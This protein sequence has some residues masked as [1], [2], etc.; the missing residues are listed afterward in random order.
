MATTKETANSLRLIELK[1][2]N[3]KR[4]QA[5]DIQF[6]NGVTIISGR[7]AQGKTSII[8]AIEGAIRG[9]RYRGDSFL[10]RGAG[11]GDVYVDLGRLRVYVELSEDGAER[12]RVTGSDGTPMKSPQAVLDRLYDEFTF[13][14]LAFTRMDPAKQRE[15]LIDL[16][17]L[18]DMLAE[19]EAERD[20]AAG[21]RKSHGDMLE[22][23]DRRLKALPAPKAGLPRE[24]VSVDD[25]TAQ[26]T[27][28]QTTASENAKVRAGLTT[29][30]GELAR[31]RQT[32]QD[33]VASLASYEER[34][35]AM[36]KAIEAERSAIKAR[37]ADLE[38]ERQRLAHLVDPSMDEIRSQLAE[39]VDTNKQVHAAH[40]WFS[41]DG[42]IGEAK[43]RYETA[44][45]DVKALDDRKKQCLAE[46][47][48]PVA[49]LGF[50]AESGVTY[51]GLPFS[52]ASSAEQLRV[53]AKV[54][55][56]RHPELR[57][58]HV[59]DGSLLDAQ[60][61]KILAECA[62]DEDY[63]VIVERVADEK[64]GGEVYIEDGMVAS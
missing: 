34:V 17:G 21:Q 12:L 30:E 61:M 35:A 28:M 60:S 13:D 52:S 42:Q 45:E 53:S 24:P 18:R 43:K 5:V 39:I 51:N 58:M 7:N 47:K 36:R 2:R 57:L 19:I 46:A 3:V 40:E 29:R 20:R 31:M 38:V 6:S 44:C 8:K 63:Q 50:D 16:L 26:L 54:G 56:S 64:R 1:A 32:L 11:S 59:E 48:W 33:H 55:M 9:K 22:Y 27:E 14:P 10:R 23:L 62:G 25:L 4:L 49:G 37:E 15:L 41:I